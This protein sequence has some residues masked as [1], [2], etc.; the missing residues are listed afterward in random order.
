M[1]FLHRHTENGH[2]HYHI[3]QPFTF[4]QIVSFRV[5]HARCTEGSSDNC[6]PVCSGESPLT[7]LH[8]RNGHFSIILQLKIWTLQ[9]ISAWFWPVGFVFQCLDY[10]YC[11]NHFG[12]VCCFHV[13]GDTHEYWEWLTVPIAGRQWGIFYMSVGRVCHYSDTGCL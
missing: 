5:A 10:K 12:D 8:P 1:T 4:R 6:Q 2:L 9:E 3:S 11:K 7:I 13:R